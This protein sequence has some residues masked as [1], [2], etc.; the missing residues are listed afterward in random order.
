VPD[1]L[2]F[3]GTSAGSIDGLGDEFAGFSEVTI[4][5]GAKWTLEGRDNIAPAT[6]SI[7]ID[8]SLTINGA[9]LGSA[10]ATIAAKGALSMTSGSDLQFGALTLTGNTLACPS[11]GMITIGNPATGAAAGT[12]TIDTGA[13]LSGFGKLVAKVAGS[14]TLAISGGN[15]T[16]QGAIG[17]NLV[18]TIAAKETLDLLGGGTIWSIGGAGA[19]KLDGTSPY[20]I[21]S[22]GTIGA[23]TV[24]IDPNAA[25]SGDGTYSGALANAGILTASGGTLSLRKS[26][27]GNGTY[28]AASRA[29]LDFTDGLTTSGTFSGAGTIRFDAASILDAGANLLASTVIENANITLGTG[30]SLTNAA[31]HTFDISP[32]SGGTITLAGATGDTFTNLNTFAC[33]GA[34]TAV[35][36]PGFVNSGNVSAGSGKLTFLGSLTN[37]GTMNAGTGVLTLASEALGAGTFTIGTAGTL[38]LENGAASAQAV[39]FGSSTGLLDLGHPLGFEGAI[40]GFT[41]KDMI[42]LL[43]TAST[44]F[45]FSGGTLTVENGTATA[46]KLAFAGFYAGADFALGSDGHGGTVVGFV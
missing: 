33:I 45:T 31:N 2:I 22:G 7:A 24:T 44:G 26:P 4:A 46:A 30:A 9:L 1:S 5:A 21:A 37:N 32:L 39:Q 13:T 40:G 23:A 17:G 34:G 28:A 35:V 16:V 6:E 12:V 38:V 29:T 41:G 19:L 42:D 15:M 25:L 11:T 8:G 14:G 36:K 3:A 20:T 27:T 10:H 18:A 43:N